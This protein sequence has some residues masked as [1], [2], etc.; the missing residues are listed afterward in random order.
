[1]LPEQAVDRWRRKAAEELRAAEA[2]LRIGDP[3]YALVCFHAQQAA[4]KVLKGWLVSRGLEPPRTHDLLLLALLAA[5]LDPRF[6]EIGELSAPLTPLAVGPRYPGDF[7][8]PGER[9]ALQALER[10][11]AIRDFVEGLGLPPPEQSLPLG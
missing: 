2:L 3:P 8:E 4:E 9:E 11:K 6:R 1:M 10:A 5:D 7:P